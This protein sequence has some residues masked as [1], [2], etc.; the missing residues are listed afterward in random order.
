MHFLGRNNVYKCK[1]VL[2]F[3]TK[4]FETRIDTRNTNHVH[5]ML[6]LASVNFFI[7]LVRQFDFNVQMT[8]Q[9]HLFLYIVI[10]FCAFKCVTCW[11]LQ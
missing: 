9:T 8:V 11:R 4:K 10:S 1:T 2:T 7:L 6:C 5:D 3:L